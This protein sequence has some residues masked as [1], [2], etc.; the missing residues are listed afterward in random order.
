[1]VRLVKSS[2][3][4]SRWQRRQLEAHWYECL[5]Y[6]FRAWPLILGLAATF[7]TLSGAA[8]LVLT[9][10]FEFPAEPIGHWLLY[11][12]FL[13][14][15]LPIVAYGCGLV[16]CVLT[17]ALAGEL[18]QIRWPERRAGLVFKSGMA[19]LVCFLAGPILPAGAAFFYWIH[20]G[21]FVPVDWVILAELLV[22]TVGYWLLGL[23]SA[24]E[25]GSLTGLD[26]ARV[27][28]LM[29]RLGARTIIAVVGAS[30]LVGLHGWLLILAL[31]ELHRNVALGVL[32][33]P[34]CWISAVF[35]AIF[36]LRLLGIWCYRTRF[37]SC[38][39]SSANSQ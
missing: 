26:P 28:S 36:L 9:G 31:V 37:E 20:G 30:A 18:K 13:L 4:R 1:L 17:S 38:R 29:S 24:R 25:K 22:V 6:P 5:S 19:W 15:A 10:E 27:V 32:L 23:M 16:D 7:T 3:P 8:L 39:P 34:F 33:L 12:G 21:D 14:V 2:T 35:W 11:S